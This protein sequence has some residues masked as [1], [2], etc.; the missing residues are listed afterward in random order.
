MT[1]DD[2]N[3]ECNGLRQEYFRRIKSYID[4]MMEAKK[5]EAKKLHE[6]FKLTKTEI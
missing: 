1:G 4:A 5:K 6:E 3:N 2:L